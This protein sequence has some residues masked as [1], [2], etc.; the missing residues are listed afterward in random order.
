MPLLRKGP[1]LSNRIG[2]P[3]ELLGISRFSRSSKSLS[4]ST[5]LRYQK[6]KKISVVTFS[7]SIIRLDTKIYVMLCIAPP[8]SKDS[9][10][11]SFRKKLLLEQAAIRQI[12]RFS[13]FRRTK[14]R[15]FR[16]FGTR[17]KFSKIL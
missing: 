4:K 13:K 8:Q 12:M 1:P 14:I 10:A 5:I 2:I 16:Q 11:Q 9:Q 3:R 17:R 15:P 6:D 7:P